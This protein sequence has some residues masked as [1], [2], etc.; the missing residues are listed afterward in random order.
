AAVAAAALGV[1]KSMT[2]NGSSPRHGPSALA[3]RAACGSGLLR[4]DSI[5]SS[6]ILLLKD[7]YVIWTYGMISSLGWSVEPDR[8]PSATRKS[9]RA[10]SDCT[11]T[12]TSAKTGMKLVSPSQRGTTCQC[13]WPGKPAPAARPTLTPRL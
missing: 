12:F 10:S 11:I 2:T 6:D 3:P 1:G 4:T 8:R 9:Y 13:K 7:R 5:S